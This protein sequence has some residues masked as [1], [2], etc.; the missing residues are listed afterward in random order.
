MGGRLNWL[1]IVCIVERS[2]PATRELETF[3]ICEVINGCRSCL[4]IGLSGLRPAVEE[5]SVC[6]QTFLR[7]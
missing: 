3:E 6:I 4:F 5:S 1:G 7:I 2:C